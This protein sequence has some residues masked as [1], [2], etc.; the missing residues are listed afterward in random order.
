MNINSYPSQISIAK[1]VTVNDHGGQNV[2]YV[3][4]VDHVPALVTDPDARLSL[5]YSQ[6][7]IIISHIIYLQTNITINTGD[8][9]Q[10]KGVNHFI[11]ARL[12]P[13]G[14]GRIYELHTTQ[15]QGQNIIIEK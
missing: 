13:S 9:V 2:S 14:T 6:R 10:Y 5:I 7:D 3:L 15:V 1:K 12:D 4:A 8:V 11:Q